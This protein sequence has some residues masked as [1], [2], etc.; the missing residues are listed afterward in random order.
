MLG[1]AGHGSHGSSSLPS[2]RERAHGTSEEHM[3][4]CDQE[5]SNMCF[6]ELENRSVH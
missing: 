4:F 5:I 3:D 2:S 1:N 6:E